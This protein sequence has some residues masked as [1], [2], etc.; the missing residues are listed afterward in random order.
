M[1]FQAQEFFQWAIDGLAAL[2]L[3]YT[4]WIHGQIK[5]IESRA[6]DKIDELASAISTI[7]VQVA[8]FESTRAA[9]DRMENK[10]D[11][12]SDLVHRIAGRQGIN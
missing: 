5:T 9:L 12:L 6:D 4:R 1:N 3:L 7:K 2:L 8:T 10:L 11:A